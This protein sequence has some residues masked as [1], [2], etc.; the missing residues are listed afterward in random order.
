MDWNFII[1]TIALITMAI[2]WTYAL[3]KVEKN[4]KY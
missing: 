4:N 1:C 2:M 3:N